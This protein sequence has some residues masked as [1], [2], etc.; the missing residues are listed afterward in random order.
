MSFS[1]VSTALTN[2]AGG[3]ADLHLSAAGPDKIKATATVGPI[4][5]TQIGTVKITGTH[6]SITWQ[7]APG[8]NGGGG[9]ITS[10]L[11][12]SSTLP[13][14]NFDI[15]KL[16][17]GLKVKSFSINQQGLSVTVAAHNT[18]LSQ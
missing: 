8:D 7:N 11:G 3:I 4:S 10:I 15:P 17:A 1:S 6:V 14:I 16:P 18:T 5:L 9:D 2:Q 13:P 12:G